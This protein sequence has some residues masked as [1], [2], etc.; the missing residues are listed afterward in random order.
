MRQDKSRSLDLTLSRNVDKKAF[1][2]MGTIT[3][4]EFKQ[5]KGNLNVSSIYF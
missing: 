1:I 3:P 4:L 5:K 2:E